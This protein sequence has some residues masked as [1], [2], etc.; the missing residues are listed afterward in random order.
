MNCLLDFR[1]LCNLLENST[2][3]NHQKNKKRQIGRV[4]Y[5]EMLPSYMQLQCRCNFANQGKNYTRQTIL[6]FSHE[7]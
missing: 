5:E 3:T 4:D 7:I 2:C 1:P 6:L